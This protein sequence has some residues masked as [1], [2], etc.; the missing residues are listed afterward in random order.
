MS[1]RL[2]TFC[3]VSLWTPHIYLQSS[4]S[5]RAFNWVQFPSP[6]ISPAPARRS[7]A[8]PVSPPPA[9]HPFS[10]ASQII[11]IK[12]SDKPIHISPTKPP[13]PHT[14]RRATCGRSSSVSSSLLRPLRSRCS[15]LINSYRAINPT[16]PPPNQPL[17]PA[18]C[19]PG[20]GL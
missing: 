17:R 15:S 9:P 19:P 7:S 4:A 16:H 14:T 2:R 12:P 13:T 18:P 6:S 10:P 5:H 8:A 11:F 3:M 1:K 20:V